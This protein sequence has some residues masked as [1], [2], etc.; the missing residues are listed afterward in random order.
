MRWFSGFKFKNDIELFKEFLNSSQFTVAGFSYGAILAFEYVLSSSERVDTLQLFSPAFFQDKDNKFIRTQLF[1]FRKN[2][3]QYVSNFLHNSFFPQNVPETFEIGKGDYNDLEK[4]LTFQ[5][6][7][8]KLE[9]VK[10]RGIKIEIFL[11]EA[12]RII[13]SKKAWQFF[14]EFGTVIYI[15]DVGHTLIK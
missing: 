15:K 9:E 12:D 2:E 1:H 3:K 8:T 6:E 11:G 10:N 13:N 7:K 4:L 14:K 5:W